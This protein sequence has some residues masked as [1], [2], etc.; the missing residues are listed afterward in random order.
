MAYSSIITDYLGQGTIAARPG[1][2]A[3]APTALGFYYADDTDVLALWNGTT[4]VAVG[5]GTVEEIVAGTGLAGGTITNSGTISLG[6]I[7]AG[8]LFG[9]AGT[10]GAVPTGIAVGAG[11]SL[12]P[13]GTIS[14]TGTTGVTS[15]VIAA[16]AFLNAGTIT[17]TGTVSS[18]TLSATGL[19]G[20]TIGTAA[21][22]V[23]IGTNLALSSGTLSATGGGGGSGNWNA[24]TVNAIGS[25]L[26][27]AAGGTLET[28]GT[29]AAGNAQ[30]VTFSPWTRP[31]L[32]SFTWVNQAS[33]T[34][35]DHTNGPLTIVQ[36]ASTDN[37]IHG[38]KIAV[39]GSTP[40]TVTAQVTNSIFTIGVGFPGYGIFITD[41]TKLILFS[42]QSQ[43][44]NAADILVQEFP[45]ATGSSAGNIL[46]LATTIVPVSSWFRITNNGTNLLFSMSNNGADWTQLASSAVGAYLGT[47]TGAGFHLFGDNLAN[48][49]IA[50]LL[51]WELSTGSGSAAAYQAS[52]GSGSGSSEWNAGTVN[53]LGSNLSLSGG[54]LSATGGTSEWTAGTVTTLG[55][56]LSLSAGTLSATGTISGGVTLAANSLLGNAGTIAATGTSL[57]IG[58]GLT[59]V[60]G[61]TL[62]V[63]G[64]AGG[65]SLEL[66]GTIETAG[67]LNF[68]SGFAGKNAS[69][70]L[71]VSGLPLNDIALTYGAVLDGK[72]AF[73]GAVSTGSPTAFSS[74]SANFVSGDV[75]KHICILGAG[76]AGA[77]LVT[78]ISAVG[79]S[80]AVTLAI[81]AS[82][83]VT[84]ANYCYGTDDTAA[85]QAAVSAAGNSPTGATITAPAG[86][87]VIAGPINTTGGASAQIVVPYISLT[88]TPAARTIEIVG[89]S[90]APAP[91]NWPTL[92]HASGTI[93]FSFAITAVGSTSMIGS[94]TGAFTAVRLNVRNLSVRTIPNSLMN[95][96]DGSHMSSFSMRDTY[97]DRFQSIDQITSAPTENGSTTGIAFLCSGRGSQCVWS[98]RDVFV[99]GYRYGHMA[100]ECG[101]IDNLFVFSCTDA[102]GFPAVDYPTIY[103]LLIVSWCPNGLVFF[104]AHAAEIFSYQTEH[105]QSGVGNGSAWMACTAD[106]YDPS[107]YWTGKIANFYEVDAGIGNKNTLITNGAIDGLITSGSG[108]IEI[109]NS[110]TSTAIPNTSTFTTVDTPTVAGGGDWEFSIELSVLLTAISGSCMIE[111]QIYDVTA[112]TAVANSFWVIANETFGSATTKTIQTAK[113]TVLR[114]PGPIGRQYEVQLSASYGS[115]TSIA[116]Q[117]SANGS[118]VTVKRA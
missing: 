48:P 7:A 9:N 92:P 74:A 25:G 67:T 63:A 77:A 91:P 116:V 105:W 103:G 112:A 33:A 20:G 94:N 43:G 55:T 53:V 35:T 32:A 102:A 36:P 14:A 85:W 71:S 117:T 39:P 70:T 60:G 58:S 16:S 109:N 61:T 95:G 89:A 82:T 28:T 62:E 113:R 30:V 22:I 42:I 106:V 98:I 24:G 111:G 44:S 101:Y 37:A 86:I 1:T 68:A 69:G 45:S 29:G 31:A 104:G 38:L 100:G 97:F 23:A 50:A 6:T 81:G 114:S 73:D 12:S 107:D 52:Y 17:G 78:T 108:G 13:G 66:N 118:Y 19:L 51:N 46:A 80:T 18:P 5:A 27:I 76:A 93:L 115:G 2:L 72:Q 56:N 57:A 83:T 96:I 88:G 47:I 59:V 99:V 49:T 34:A 15:V 26:T 41:G 79:S 4:W 8:E 110:I 64:G 90:P 65:V 21:S 54:T 40:W 75:G 10:V 11:L 84:T 3:I 87:S